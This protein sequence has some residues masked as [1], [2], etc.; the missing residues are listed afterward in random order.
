MVKKHILAVTLIIALAVVA[1][2]QP[3]AA[4]YKTQPPALP[5][6]FHAPKY[7]DDTTDQHGIRLSGGP[8]GRSSPV[9]AEVDGNAGNGNEVVVGGADGRVYAY[10][11][12][13]TLLWEKTVPDAGC[14]GFSMING[15]ATVGPL[16][17]GSTPYVLIGYGTIEST[18][19]ACDG[20]VVVF[21]GSDGQQIWNFSLQAFESQ[22]PEGPENLHGVV[23]A[24]TIADTDGNGTMEV[25]FGGLDRNVYL[26]N[27]DG[28]VRW[29]YH[30]A[31]TVWSTP[32]FLNIDA[33]SQLELIV[34]TDIS[35]NPNVR[36]VTQDGGFLHAFETAARSPARIEFQTGFI[37]R[38]YFD[39]ALFSSPLAADLLA[40]NGGLELALGASCYFPT[41]GATKNGRWIKLVNPAT[42]ALLQTLNAPGCVQSSPAAGDI[43]G[44]GNLEIVATVNGAGNGGDGLSRIV[45]W[46]PEAANPKWQQ[47]PYNPNSSPNN[48]GG[49][50]ANGGDLQ[51]A[52]IAD[53]DGNGS[54]EVLAANFWSVHVLRGSD[55]A[56][57]TC[58]NTS[59]GSQLA[60]FAWGTLK[61]TPAVGDV[62]GDGD[63]DVVIGGTNSPFDPNRGL[64][65]GWTNFA[66]ILGSPQGNQ[67]AYS[68]PWPQFLRNA[69]GRALLSEPGLT[70]TVSTV[71]SVFESG[72]SR[73]YR[74]AIG[75]A[76]GGPI[77]PT[78]SVATDP[79]GIATASMDGN[80]LV[81]TVSA[82]GQAVGAYSA[83]VEVDSAGL[84]TLS[85][86]VNLQVVANVTTVNLPA[87]NR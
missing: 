34:A 9:I 52:V 38:T 17:G 11:A 75:S 15:R 31:D 8:I 32:L 13:G 47:V 48:P 53:L 80:T 85:F 41:S 63:L 3:V 24:P 70:T 78:A 22:T 44:D 86:T 5:G 51:S 46:D 6:W 43:D 67:G 73:S 69:A 62:D 21:R 61:S 45:A 23:G 40:S 71:R 56:F 18:N 27:S 68:A 29:F 49:H 12:N 77:S 10:R 72:D 42:G 35:A 1:L 37:W 54:L 84:P 39:Q 59:C 16:M 33:D 57:L 4:S 79:D 66:G 30:A 76:D 14:S 55:G 74:I 87:T 2:A 60:L 26:L 81:L 28:S 50:D 7:G 19:R 20:G 25:A 36:P 58:Q 83:T 82:A 64:L 65:Y